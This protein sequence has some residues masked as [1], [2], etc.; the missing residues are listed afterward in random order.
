MNKY[1]I[2]QTT[3]W[4][5]AWKMVTNIIW[6]N[7]PLTGSVLCHN[8]PKKNENEIKKNKNSKQTK[9]VGS[10]TFEM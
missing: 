9:Q 4:Y 6:F 7:V 10:F 2:K 5:H 3:K 1:L 8:L